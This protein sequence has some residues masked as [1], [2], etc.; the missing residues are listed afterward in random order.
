MAQGYD[1][2]ESVVSTI[3]R[4]A[5]LAGYR[6]ED[7]IPLCY[8]ERSLEV[9]L[10]VIMDDGTLRIFEGYRVQHS[11]TRG[12]GKGGVRFHP[13]VNEREV[14]ALAAWMTLKCAVVNIPYGG[15]K[16]GVKV[17]P[18]KL[19]RDELRRLTRRY[20]AA[21][22]P[23]IGPE[24]DIPAPDVGTDPEVMA[25]M[26]DTYSVMKGHCIPGVV[27]GKPIEIGGAVG[28]KAAT[29]RGVLFTVENTLKKMGKTI[30]GTVCAVQGL[31]N[32]GGSTVRLLDEQGAKIVAVSDVSGALY[33]KEG[34]PVKDILAWT[35]VRGHLLADLEVPG[36][37]RITNAELLALPVEVLIP[38]ALE[39]QINGANAKDV[40][41]EV[42]VEAANGPVTPEADAIL[43]EKGIMVVPDILANAGGV[44]VSYFEWV[45][46]IQS[47][48][49][50]ETT[51]NEKLRDVM[52]RAFEEVWEMKEKHHT[53]CRM[54]AY[55]IAVQ[56]VADA[57]NIR[58]IWP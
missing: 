29:G 2:Y 8:P 44:V 23:I 32:V 37:Q 13:S 28:R 7:Y 22:G 40:R 9:S 52:D 1:P 11:T 50:D 24:Q 18:S 33:C 51:I 42:I 43:L 30:R 14:A 25:W 12:P 34:L 49:W 57:K 5:E 6:E 20:T 39:N 36:A 15:A 19:S 4:A 38:A 27:T 17:D 48:Y 10:P 41:A 55:A 31:G 53:T 21:I 54:A 58:G 3:R 16:G 35:S 46:N 56:R 47:L 26:M 45:Q